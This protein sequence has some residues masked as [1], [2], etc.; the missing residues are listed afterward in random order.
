M[1]LASFN[2]VL[3][4]PIATI[5]LASTLAASIVYWVEGGSEIV[6]SSL[7]HTVIYKPS[8]L[9]AITGSNETRIRVEVRDAL[10][11]P[12]T[13][14]A[15]LSGPTFE[16][17]TSLGVISGKGSAAKGIGKYVSQVRKLLRDVNSDPKASGVGLLLLITT[18]IEEGGEYYAAVD[19][20]SAP[21]IPDKAVGKEIKVIV[22]F[23]PI[24]KYKIETRGKVN[25]Q[26]QS[27]PPK[28]EKGCFELECYYYELA[29][30]LYVTPTRKV[31]GM[32]VNTEYIPVAI[33]KLDQDIGSKTSFIRHS[34]ELR[35]IEG[36]LVEIIL[37]M[38][39]GFKTGPTSITISTPGA[40]YIIKSPEN[41]TIYKVGC[42][43][44]STRI[45]TDD[46]ACATL[47]RAYPA[48]KSTGDVIFSTGFLGRIWVASYKLI[49]DN[50]LNKYVIRDNDTATWLVPA[51]NDRGEIIASWE[52]DD[53][54]ND[55]I[56]VTEN[57]LKSF[58][59]NNTY[60]GSSY[61]EYELKMEKV[62]DYSWGLSSPLGGIGIPVGALVAARLG[63]SLTNPL[64]LI[65]SLLTIIIS[66]KI[67]SKELYKYHGTF[68]IKLG[69]IFDLIHAHF[70]IVE[71]PYRVDGE[72]RIVPA[73]IFI[74]SL[75]R[76]V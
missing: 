67:E 29:E 42:T 56:G 75:R 22:T 5:I 51:F 76:L 7:G 43:I 35:F 63:L 37:G 58:N 12:L 18:V 16:N 39:I 9:N 41:K 23:K 69:S 68:Y 38:S 4:L 25:N 31:D 44:Y 55:G 61:G 71:R 70:A 36:W 2:K 65:L 49:A 53:Y 15:S 26:V 72:D 59:Y 6:Y 54:P 48:N 74:P 24:V 8:L 50:G 32:T 40:S 34:F 52:L 64:F 28:I 46:S 10:G 1:Q 66:A 45:T 13:F 62:Y 30:I 33:T 20:V 11:R 17:V 73:F 57:T 60:H 47:G 19:A 21:I 27:P 14:A 3:A